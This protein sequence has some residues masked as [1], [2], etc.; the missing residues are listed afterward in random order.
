M[1]IANGAGEW[2]LQ[3]LFVVFGWN[4]V[5][6]IYK[7]FYFVPCPLERTVFWGGGELFVFPLLSVPIGI[8]ELPA[9]LVASLR[10]KEKNISRELTTAFFLWLQVSS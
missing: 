6:I 1:T 4:K 5:V 2:G 8:S 3:F 7:F 9:S 10:Q